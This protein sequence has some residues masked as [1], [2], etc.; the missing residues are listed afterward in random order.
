[1]GGNIDDINTDDINQNFKIDDY[2]NN[3]NKQKKIKKLDNDF[4]NNNS[5]EKE[6][7]NYKI[8]NGLRNNKRFLTVNSKENNKN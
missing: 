4:L 2:Q 6:V 3:L 1:M 5:N 7:M 8:R